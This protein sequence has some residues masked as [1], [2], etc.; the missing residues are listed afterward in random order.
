MKN[1]RALIFA[2]VFAALAVFMIFSYINSFETK[3]ESKYQK[4]AIV[5]AKKDIKPNTVLTSS[6]FEKH[7]VPKPY[8]Q[9]GSV[10]AEEL[11]DILSIL[12]VAQTTI[13]E[14][15]QLL[16]TKI[17]LFDDA[18]ISSKIPKGYRACTVA[19][20]DISGVGGHIQTGDHVDIIGSFRT[21]EDKK[22]TVKDLEA[23]T[24]FQDVPIL[25]TGRDN[26]FQKI[27]DATQTDKSFF[28]G[29]TGRSSS[30]GHVTLQMT[31]R[32][33]MDL[34]I[35]QEV[36]SI[37]LA[38]RSFQERNMGKEIDSLKSQRSTTKS[39][40]G[41]EEQVEVRSTPKWLELRGEQGVFTQ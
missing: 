37:T 2:L 33:C 23:V 4:E 40:T 39:V 30:F 11:A 34:A 14:G 25:A 36:G 15:E 5:V 41:I 1:R 21:L 32:G 20:S 26:R 28:S 6:H 22:Q 8:V 9:P 16:R 12:P 19:V 29:N 17:D 38:L 10:K 27:L 13:L 3:Y 31:P 7:L 24:L 18:K 35:A